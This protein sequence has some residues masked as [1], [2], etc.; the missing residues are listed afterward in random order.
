M[1]QNY[2]TCNHIHPNGNRCRGAALRHQQFCLHHH[3]THRPSSRNPIP[4][5]TQISFGL[6]ALNSA[7]A[8]QIALSDVAL[9]VANGTLDIHR[10]NLI[11]SVLQ[12]ARANLAAVSGQAPA[13]VPDSPDSP[14]IAAD[15][16]G[17]MALLKSPSTADPADI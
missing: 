7:T 6:P 2:P 8:I 17:I 10:A 9:R 16:A 1:S 4:R 12:I 14:D 5:A 13:P 15:L 3:P 11:L